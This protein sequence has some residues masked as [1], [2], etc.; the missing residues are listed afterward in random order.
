MKKIE[1]NSIWYSQPTVLTREVSS[2]LMICVAHYNDE[3][4]V[5]ISLKETED[6][7]LTL[8]DRNQI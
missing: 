3:L 1:H 4:C 7:L 2:N 6:T 8:T 5:G